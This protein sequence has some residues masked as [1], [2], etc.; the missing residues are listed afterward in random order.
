[1]K[2]NFRNLA[3]LTS[4]IFFALAL[5]WMLAP[6]LLLASWGVDFSSSAELVGR[7]AAALYTGIGV[8]FFSARNTEPS[9]ARSALLKGAAVVC[10]MLAVLGVFELAADHAKVGILVAVFIEIAL[11]VAFLTVRFTELLT[12]QPLPKTQPHSTGNQG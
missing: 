7:R 6:K 8:M 11:T 4:F 2:L 1:M 12:S 3:I 5:T 10:L 9:P